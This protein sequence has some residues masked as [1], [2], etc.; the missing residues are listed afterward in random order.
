MTPTP[1]SK[2]M[3]CRECGQPLPLEV[4]DLVCNL[5]G[6]AAACPSCVRAAGGALAYYVRQQVLAMARRKEGGSRT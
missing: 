3:F 2:V 4:N 5:G 1:T 6:S